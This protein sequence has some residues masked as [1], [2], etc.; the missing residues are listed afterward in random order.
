VTGKGIRKVLL[1]SGCCIAVPYMR[2]DV[3]RF[4]ISAHSA[5]ALSML[6]VVSWSLIHKVIELIL[7]RHYGAE[8]LISE[9]IVTDFVQILSI[10]P[11]GTLG[12]C[13]FANAML[14]SVLR[15]DIS[16]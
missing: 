6:A 10:H 4:E 3:M 11:T 7:S 9:Q 15:Y 5:T 8:L 12:H 2:A 14:S 13:T 16:R 1:A